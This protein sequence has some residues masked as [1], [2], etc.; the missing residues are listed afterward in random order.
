MCVLLNV[1]HDGVFERVHVE[2]DFGYERVI[3]YR[4]EKKLGTVVAN[5]IVAQVDGAD[6]VVLLKKSD[7]RQHRLWSQLVFRQI[8]LGELAALRIIKHATY[9]VLDCLTVSDIVHLEDEADEFFVPG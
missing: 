7:E 5:R 1:V 2:R 8:N 9:D 4:L 6:F 3:Y